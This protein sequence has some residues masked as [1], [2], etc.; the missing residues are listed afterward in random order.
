MFCTLPA[1][2][3]RAR[4]SVCSG[5]L[6]AACWARRSITLPTAGAGPVLYLTGVDA[7]MRKVSADR[8]DVLLEGLLDMNESA[9]PRAVGE[10]LDG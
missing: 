6:S 5:S 1:T 2:N 3:W 8:V 7:L 10:V 4:T 9:L